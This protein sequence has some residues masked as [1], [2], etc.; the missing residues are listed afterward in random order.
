MKICVFASGSGTNFKAILESRKQ[1][2]IE[3]DVGLLITNNS[4]CGAAEIAREEGIEVVHISRKVFPDLSSQDYSNLFI[5][6]LEKNET[7][8]IVLAGYMK[9]LPEEV[10]KKYSN[11]IINIH[12]ALLP[13]YGG[14]GMYGINVHKAVIENGERETGV[15]VHYVT[16]NYDEGEIIYQERVP[17]NEN[18]TP[19]SLMERMKEVEHRVY[20]K[21]I[22]NLESNKH[23]S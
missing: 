7:D 3:S 1:G 12:P 13:K 19:E 9:M 21:V 22:K 18:E 10:V 11:R 20:P 4:S 6:A 16:E 17:V 23:R 5:S 15:S 14:K 8:L 2:E